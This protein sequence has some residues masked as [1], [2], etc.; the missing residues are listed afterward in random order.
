LKNLQY[1]NLFGNNKLSNLEGIEV[2]TSLND[3]TIGYNNFESFPM[4]IMYL[5]NLKRLSLEGLNF[6]SFPDSFF[7]A[8]LPIE[9]LQMSNMRRFDYASNLSKFHEL[10]NLRE[11]YLQDNIPK[12]NIDFEKCENLETFGYGYKKNINIVDILNRIA[13]APKLKEL[14]LGYNNIRYLPQNLVLPDSLEKLYLFNNNIK[15]L[16]V[17]ITKYTNLKTIDLHDNPIDTTAIKKIEKEMV[18]TKFYYDG[19]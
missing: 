12:L 15:K 16:P 5:K 18:N 14:I 3:L 13:K 9:R 19:K 1:L 10:N 7:I 8:G 2:L 17:K 6:K 4:E 11:L